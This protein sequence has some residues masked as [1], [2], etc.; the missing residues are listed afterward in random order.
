MDQSIN[1]GDHMESGER[2]QLLFGWFHVVTYAEL[3]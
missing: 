3:F 2:Q 1:D